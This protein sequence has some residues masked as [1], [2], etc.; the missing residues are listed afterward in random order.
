[1]EGRL[2]IGAAAVALLASLP[3]SARDRQASYLV[4]VTNHRAAAV[5]KLAFAAAG[6]EHGSPNLLRHPLA[7]NATVKLHV[8]GPEGVCSFVVAGLFADGTEIYGEGLN[9][10]VDRTVSLVD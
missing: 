8:S 1:M 10:C 6:A 2:W 3:A 7:S 5:D 9:L 4:T